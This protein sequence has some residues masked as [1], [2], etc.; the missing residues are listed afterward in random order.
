M[1]RWIQ[2]F[3]YGLRVFADSTPLA[4]TLVQY[5]PSASM[6]QGK[7]IFPEPVQ[8]DMRF[9]VRDVRDQ[10]VWWIESEEAI[11][12]RFSDATSVRPGG[13]ESSGMA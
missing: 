7:G 11:Q 2:T 12:L 4:P 1:S 6:R 9:R 3:M 13:R 10:K 5:G 8:F